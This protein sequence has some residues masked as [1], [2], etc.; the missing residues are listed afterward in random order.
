MWKNI[1]IIIDSP[2]AAKF[3]DKY[4]DFK[5]LWDAEAKREI[6]S[7]RHPLSFEQLYTVDSHQEHM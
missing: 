1:D 6:K 3:T 2:M 4:Q 7:G 5:S